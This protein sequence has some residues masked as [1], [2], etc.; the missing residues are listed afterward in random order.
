VIGPRAVLTTPEESPVRLLLADVAAGAATANLSSAK[1]L[2]ERTVVVARL[3]ELLP[4]LVFD[5]R[6]SGTFARGGYTIRFKLEGE[7]PDVVDVE[8]D[9]PEAFAPVKRIAERTGWRPVDPESM[10]FIDLDASKAIGATV[11]VGEPEAPEP[12]AEEESSATRT[13]IRRAVLAV[14]AVTALWGSWE[15]ARS[16]PDTMTPLA[17]ARTQRMS[18]EAVRWAAERAQRRMAIIKAVA[19]P[20][21]ANTVVLQLYDMWIASLE[22]RAGFGM[23]RFAKIENLSDEGAWARFN[24][25][26]PLPVI[27]AEAERDGYLFEFMGEHCGPMANNMSAPPDDCDEFIYMA[28]PLDM[29]ERKGALPPSFAL[30]SEDGR[31]H[32]RPNGEYPTLDDPTVDNPGPGYSQPPQGTGG[33][34]AGIGRAVSGVFSRILGPSKP[35]AASIA[36]AESSAIQDLRAVAQAEVAVA[37]MLNGDKYVPPEMLA[38]AKLF[39]RV[40]MPALLPAYFSQPMRMGYA[41]VFE[42]EH[43][44]VSPETFSW[45]SEVYGSFVYVARPIEPGPPGRRSFALYP[46]GLIYSTAEDRAPTRADTPVGQ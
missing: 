35:S 12:E 2:G 22:Y 21:R 38:D 26:P 1:P 7:L 45:L 13:N 46:D 28:R 11:L 14:V 41:F 44:T 31:I 5:D 24:V 29:P 25:P 10:G 8:I 15:Y 37:A 34:F 43:L 9:K 39:G 42:G 4:G 30:F 3:K 16:R 33:I 36:A 23:G 32:F 40:R 20:F 19:P 17:V 27:F 18:D 6:G